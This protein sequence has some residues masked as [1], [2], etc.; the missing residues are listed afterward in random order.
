M[1]AN[2]MTVIKMTT[3]AVCLQSKKKKIN[4]GCNECMDG[5][6]YA[7]TVLQN[8]ELIKEK[9]LMYSL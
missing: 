1:L 2:I 7:W 3:I 5:K 4:S 9:K 6:R 8:T